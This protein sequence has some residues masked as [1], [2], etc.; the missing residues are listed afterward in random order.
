VTSAYVV[1]EG[2]VVQ[3]IALLCRSHHIKN[4]HTRDACAGR[5]SSH[6]QAEIRITNKKILRGVIGIRISTIRPTN[7]HFYQ[8]ICIK[9]FANLEITFCGRFSSHRRSSASEIAVL[10]CPLPPV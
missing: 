2:G 1:L 3:L 4:A 7:S 8:D 9:L 10:L 5:V 6:L